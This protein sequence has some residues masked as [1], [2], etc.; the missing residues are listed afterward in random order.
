M[1]KVIDINPYVSLKKAQRLRLRRNEIAARINQL[2]EE[3]GLTLTDVV[4][5]GAGCKAI[6][7]LVNE[8]IR[9]GKEYSGLI[10][11]NGAA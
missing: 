3:Q 6:R 4:H 9:S 10:K 1:G 11:N 2:S 5:K 7:W 8:F